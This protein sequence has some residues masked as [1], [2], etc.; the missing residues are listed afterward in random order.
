MNNQELYNLSKERLYMIYQD[1]KSSDIKTEI[2]SSIQFFDTKPSELIWESYILRKESKVVH[3]GSDLIV[4][5]KYRNYQNEDKALEDLKW[6]VDDNQI[7][8]YFIIKNAIL[9]GCEFFASIIKKSFFLIEMIIY[10]IALIQKNF[11][12]WM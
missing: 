12:W 1:L 11:Y 6:F 3:F 5:E 8:F 2:L 10:C 9:F 4:D 7:F